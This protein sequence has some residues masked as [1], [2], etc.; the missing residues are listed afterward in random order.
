MHSKM[1]ARPAACHWKEFMR[2]S[3]KW[4]RRKALPVQFDGYARGQTIVAVIRAADANKN[5]AK[6]F[7]TETLPNFRRWTVNMPLPFRIVALWKIASVMHP[8]RF[9]PL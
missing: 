8:A 3:T 7:Q 1:F 9:F 2:T 4:I 6:K 5:L